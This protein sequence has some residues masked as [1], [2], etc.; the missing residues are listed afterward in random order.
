MNATDQVQ[1]HKQ[2]SNF[3]FDSVRLGN[4]NQL[5]DPISYYM[6]FGNSIQD[7]QIRRP[8]HEKDSCF[9]QMSYS[10]TH[11]ALDDEIEGS[12]NEGESLF[13]SVNLPEEMY[14]QD[15]QEEVNP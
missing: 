7:N 1:T 11:R 13:L 3:L 12:S 9:V 5:R 2:L 6:K 10:Q 8:M 14:L 4:E 15:D